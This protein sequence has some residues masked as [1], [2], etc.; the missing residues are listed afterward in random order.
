MVTRTQIDQADPHS[1]LDMI[2]SWRG[3]AKDIAGHAD[4]YRQ[5]VTMPGGQPWSGQTRDTAV[6]LAAHD[7]A[8]IGRVRDAID[9][10]ADAAGNDVNYRVIPNL[11]E[12]RAKIAAAEANGF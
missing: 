7:Y 8:Q 10:M 1:V 3:S 2:D 5:A 11:N 6:A 4:T 12:V 9:S